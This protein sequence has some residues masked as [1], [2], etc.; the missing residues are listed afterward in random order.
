MF[1]IK[2]TLCIPYLIDKILSFFY[3]KN[4][5]QCGCNVRIRPLSS[6]F[7]G[8]KNLSIGDFSCVPK[9]SVFYCTEA[10]LKIGRKV[11]FG[12]HP[13]IITGNHRVDVVG[14]Y[15]IDSNVK[16][17]ENDAPVI[18]EDDV[19]IGA[20]VTILKGVTVGRGSVIGAGAVVTKSCLPYSVIGGVPAR[21]IKMRF[22]PS[23]IRDHEFL[24]NTTR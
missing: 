5:K 23:E 7:K 17:P 18:I 22:T 19:W 21:L 9:R 11:I 1:F 12:P 3:K 14:T 8:L 4:M 16:E 15:I 20:N 6:D 2:F 24:L 13:T 10:E